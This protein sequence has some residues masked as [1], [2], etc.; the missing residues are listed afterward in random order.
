MAKPASAT[1][2]AAA[3]PHAHDHRRWVSPMN[4]V[5]ASSADTVTAVETPIGPRND[6]ESRSPSRSALIPPPRRAMRIG[7][8]AM[9]AETA[10][11]AARSMTIAHR[12][13]GCATDDQHREPPAADADERAG[14]GDGGQ[15]R[16]GEPDR[17]TRPGAAGDVDRP[18]G[19]GRA[20]MEHR[21]PT[22]AV[23]VGGDHAPGDRVRP[24][25]EAAVEG[26]DDVDVHDA[27]RRRDRRAGVVEHRRRSARERHLLAEPQHGFRRRLGEHGAVGRRHVEQLGVGGRRAR[28]HEHGADDSED[29]RAQPPSHHRPILAVG[30]RSIHS[31]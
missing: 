8:A 24:V 13:V 16:G 31:V 4:A 20:D 26:D 11:I 28:R 27:R 21:R 30:R 29:E 25:A 7:I 6:S 3:A 17:P 15:D 19:G 2:P 10:R 22:D 1:A 9:S 23:R 14:V 12:T 5:I 18:A